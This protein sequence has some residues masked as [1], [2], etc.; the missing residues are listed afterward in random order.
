MS[1]KYTRFVIILLVL[2]Q[3]FVPG[4]LQ[5]YAETN[6]ASKQPA[7]CAWPSETMSLYFDFQ[8]DVIAAIDSSAASNWQTFNSDSDGRLFTN[9]DLKLPSAL[10]YVAGNVLWNSSS[11][12]S[13]TA[14]S[15]ILLLLAS[16]SVI[17]SDVEWFAIFFK[18]RPIVRDYRK[19]LDIESEIFETAFIFSRN[20]D[21]TRTLQWSTV[22]EVNRVIREY[23]AAWLLRDWINANWNISMANILSDLISMNASMKFFIAMGGEVWASEL[24]SYAWCFWQNKEVECNDSNLVLWFD[25][26]A[27]EKLKAEYS[28]TWWYWACNSSV[29]NITNT[30]S[31]AKSNASESV[32]WAID[33][34]KISIENLK[35]ALIWQGTW[36]KVL[37]DPCKMSDYERAQIDAYWWWDWTCWEW[38]SISDVYQPIKDYINNKKAMRWQNEKADNVV[39]SSSSSSAPSML[40]VVWNIN[41]L[42]STEEKEVMWYRVFSGETIYNPE[43]SNAL[44][45][46]FYAVFDEV[47]EEFSS[48]KSAAMALDLSYELAK[49]KWLVNQVDEA[50]TSAD[51]LRRDL[52][53]IA[54]YQCSM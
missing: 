3:L 30:Y 36:K 21:L 25:S 13:T 51:Q 24:I 10:D 48:S 26:E 42:K 37:T 53:D 20:I 35:N 47:S 2:F 45:N 27:V 34:I 23:R 5:V 29:S 41:K 12:I 32:R 52:Q 18:D 54:D 1:K 43:F 40:D 31:K 19:M 11:I 44:H 50:M 6:N 33:D 7:V 9:N 16:K 39:K 8:R 14:T 49:V 4:F 17:E 38:I 15:V 28:G 46:D 22:S